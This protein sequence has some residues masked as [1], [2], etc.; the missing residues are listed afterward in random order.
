MPA[1]ADLLYSLRN[2]VLYNFRRRH[3]HDGPFYLEVK[4]KV[5]ISASEIDAFS[6]DLL[7]PTEPEMCRYRRLILIQ[8]PKEQHEDVSQCLTRNPS[9]HI[10][11]VSIHSVL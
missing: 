3:D 6:E 9:A 4:F 8:D 7:F 11:Q 10:I 1:S 2:P 5:H